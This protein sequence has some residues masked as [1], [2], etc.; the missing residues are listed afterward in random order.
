MPEP[1]R[2]GQGCGKW[3]VAREGQKKKQLLKLKSVRSIRL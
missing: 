1:A 2:A 3:T